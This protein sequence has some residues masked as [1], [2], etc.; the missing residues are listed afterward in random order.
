MR[1]IFYGT[2]ACAVPFLELL[3]RRT[4]V[5]A[6]VSQ[7]DK[8][9]GRSLQLA[10][11][12]VKVRALALGLPVLQPERPAA[13]VEQLRRLNPDLAVAVAYGRLLPPDILALPVLGSLNVHFSLLPKY[14]G[15]APVQWSLAR[16]ETETG[17]TIFWIEREL[18][19]G[20]VFRQE[21]LAIDPDEDAEALMARLTRSGLE[22]LGRVLED[23]VAG[24]VLKQAQAG[25]PTFAPRIRREDARISWE[26]PARE[27]HDLVRG[28]RLWPTAYIQL[29][30]PGPRSVQVLKTRL[31][32]PG[33]AG[34]LG[35][36]SASGGSIVRVERGGGI[37]V[38]CKDRSSIWL[39]TVQPEG[40]KP[41][42]AAD[43][44][45]GLRLGVGGSLPLA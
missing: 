3:A 36:G 7:P 8:P 35:T 26:R 19:S 6:V 33:E 15:A 11:S 27:I 14:R 20:P 22:A 1:A 42:A 32:T 30:A 38:Q 12:P 41:V 5:V 29:K 40:K 44:I 4:S 2:P 25:T 21:R 37:L 18:D 13:V 28:F 10:A 34:G 45:N 31:P 43:F 17:V 23:L 39:L 9:A 16:G 24:R